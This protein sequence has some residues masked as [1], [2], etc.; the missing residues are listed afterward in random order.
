M[1]RSVRGAALA[2]LA[3]IS[4]VAA[5]AALAQDPMTA[6][7]HPLV[8]AW[9][10]DV[11]TADQN[12]PPARVIF[13]SDGTLIQVNPTGAAI[14]VWEPTGERTGA[15]TIAGES[16]DAAGAL[17]TGTLRAT[18]EVAADGQSWTAQATGEYI[19][20]DGVSS[21]QIGPTA[22]TAARVLV[23]PMTPVTSPAP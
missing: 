3:L 1:H 8:G 13:S 15:L 6:A 23:E 16:A 17:S 5:P 18:V 14:G 4:L 19:G 20:P 9:L 7:G 11:N 2:A 12:D 21:G 10:V 22:A